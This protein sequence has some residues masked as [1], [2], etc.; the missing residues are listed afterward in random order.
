MRI[1]VLGATGRTGGL[2]V[3]RA[4]ERGMDV[5]A[6][7]RHDPDP[8]LDASVTV[9]LLDLRDQDA[10]APAL[11]GADA[12]VSAIGPVAGVTRTEISET[13]QAVVD[14]M[15]RTGVR[16]IVAAANGTVLTDKEITG[17]YANLAAEHRRDAAILRASGLDWTLLAAP[18]LTDDPA[19][20]EVA[21]A[22]DA[23]AAGRSLT[24][25]DY[26]AALLDALDRS[27]W[28]GHIVGVAN[29]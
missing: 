9:T 27:E 29:P 7:V 12:V 13:T 18:Y 4:L 3:D 26:A 23:K 5:V 22:V 20:G 16:R 2:L 14:A 10:I 28:V 15:V 1:A 11:A 17:E 25:G 21:T 6:L 19:T 24:R 8:P